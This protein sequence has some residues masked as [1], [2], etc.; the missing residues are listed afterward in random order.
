LINSF[1]I[2]PHKDGPLQ[3]TRKRHGLSKR[4]QKWGEIGSFKERNSMLGQ[5]VR[6]EAMLKKGRGGQKRRKPP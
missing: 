4:G 5:C 3:I 1:K 2:S 6:N